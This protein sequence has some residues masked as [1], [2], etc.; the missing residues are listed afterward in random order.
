MKEEKSE[1]RKEIVV[2]DAGIDMDDATEPF[3]FCCGGA[4]MPLR[5]R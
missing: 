3:M 5:A 4:F 1:E 2:L